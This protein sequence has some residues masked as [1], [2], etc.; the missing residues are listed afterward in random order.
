MM[1]NELMKAAANIKLIPF[2]PL[3]YRSFGSDVHNEN[4]ME[5][6]YKNVR[7]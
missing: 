4:K 5:V 3:Y 2:S 1:Y 7:K 6:I